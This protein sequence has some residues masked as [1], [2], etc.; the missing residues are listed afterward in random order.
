MP[1]RSRSDHECYRSH[2][3][4]DVHAFKSGDDDLMN[5]RHDRLTVDDDFVIDDHDWMTRDHDRVT[6]DDR[7]SARYSSFNIQPLLMS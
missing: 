7:R 5:Q 4:T 6:R 2:R 1:A 3:I